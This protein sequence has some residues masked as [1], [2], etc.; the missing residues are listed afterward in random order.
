MNKSLTVTLL[1]LVVS[2][3]LILGAFFIPP[4]Q[5]LFQGTALF[6]LPF[7]IFSLLGIVLIFLTLREKVKGTLKRYL[8]L[9][10][11]SALG[12]FTFIFL[13]NAF[14]A[15]NMVTHHITVLNYL[16]EIL[17][18]IFFLAAILLCPLGFLVGI[19]GTTILHFKQKR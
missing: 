3:L 12:F 5:N 14:Y 17:H 11:A 2:F 10:G 15:L 6:L 1:A 8:L 13:H 9:T 19:V 16:T 18:T 4:V 7:I